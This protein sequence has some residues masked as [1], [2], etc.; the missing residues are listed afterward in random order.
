MPA[1]GPY[2]LSTAAS[3]HTFFQDAASSSWAAG[4]GRAVL[5]AVR[6]LVSGSVAST[7]TIPDLQMMVTTESKEVH[8]IALTSP[9]NRD[10]LFYYKYVFSRSR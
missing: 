5:R 9:E 7:E 2:K 10:G 4:G 1:P 6:H 3:C 8:T